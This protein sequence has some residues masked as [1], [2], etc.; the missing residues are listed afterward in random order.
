M[1]C[2]AAPPQVRRPTGHKRLKRA[3]E[4]R[5][6]TDAEE[7]RAELF[8]GDEGKFRGVLRAIIRTSRLGGGK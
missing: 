2:L 1:L 7:M 6:A 8:G 4:G 5:R 3:G